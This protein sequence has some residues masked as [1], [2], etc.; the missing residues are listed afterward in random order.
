MKNGGSNTLPPKSAIQLGLWIPWCAVALMLALLCW[1]AFK[2]ALFRLEVTL[3][4]G[5]AMMVEEMRDAALTTIRTT[6]NVTER[7]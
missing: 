2:S 7:S 5:H 4:D 3:A 1:T 6:R